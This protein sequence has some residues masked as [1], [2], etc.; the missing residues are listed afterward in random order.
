MNLKKLIVPALFLYCVFGGANASL[1][2]GAT[3][4]IGSQ[5]Y[6]YDGVVS[7][8]VEDFDESVKSYG[9][10][11]GLDV[12]IFRIEAEYNR[13]DS[14]FVKTNLAMVNVL[15]KVFP[16]SVITPYL[17]VGTG[18]QFGG[19]VEQPGGMIY[20]ANNTRAI[21]GMLGLTFSIP[22]TSMKIDAE[23]RAVYMSDFI[24][25]EEVTP[26]SGSVDTVNY[27]GRIKIRYQF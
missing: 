26:V 7:L 15:L 25:V 16:T 17:G 6:K 14:K 10:L 27:E 23:A 4:G 18:M 11:I 22:E 20:D 24:P 3:G 13:L 2:I 12:P 21:Q 9:V 1:Y 19:E 5:Q 8:Y